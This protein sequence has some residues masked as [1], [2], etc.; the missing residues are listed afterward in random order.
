MG[1]LPLFITDEFAMIGRRLMPFSKYILT[2]NHITLTILEAFMCTSL[3]MLGSY[4][5]QITYFFLRDILL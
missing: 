2:V 1:P 3:E 5:L 4:S